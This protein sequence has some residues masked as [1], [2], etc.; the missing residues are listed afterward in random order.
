MHGNVYGNCR[1]CA[2]DGSGTAALL[3]DGFISVAV[4]I[5]AANIC[6]YAQ[7]AVMEDVKG[8]ML[9]VVGALMAAGNAGGD[10]AIGKLQAIC[11]SGDWDYTDDSIDLSCDKLLG[12]R[13]RNR[14]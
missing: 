6:N 10:S 11:T 1:G 4:F 14:V 9:I 2:A 7:V 3:C 12:D 8:Y 13:G 5:G